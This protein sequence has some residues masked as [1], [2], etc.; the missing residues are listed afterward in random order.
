MI[1]PRMRSYSIYTYANTVLILVCLST[2]VIVYQLDFSPFMIFIF[3]LFSNSS[4]MPSVLPSTMPDRLY[5]SEV[6]MY[7]LAYSLWLAMST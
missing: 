2:L 7:A 4:I 5:L 6:F 3:A 1:I